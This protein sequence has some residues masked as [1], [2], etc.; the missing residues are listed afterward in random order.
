MCGARFNHLH[1][2]GHSLD[3]CNHKSPHTWFIDFQMVEL[4]VQPTQ[5]TLVRQPISHPQRGCFARDGSSNTLFRSGRVNRGCTWQGLLSVHLQV[6]YYFFAVN[7]CKKNCQM[8]Y[9]FCGNASIGLHD[10]PQKKITRITTYTHTHTHWG[11]RVERRCTIS[12]LCAPSAPSPVTTCCP[13]RALR[14]VLPINVAKKGIGI[15]YPTCKK[16]F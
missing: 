15:V 13:A 1:P 10:L 5:D 11:Q 4:L 2:P 16:V 7:A 6:V 14:R 12:H 8:V 9:C 3:I